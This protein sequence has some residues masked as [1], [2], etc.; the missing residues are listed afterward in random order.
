M[1]K[2][3]GSALGHKPVLPLGCSSLIHP[4]NTYSSSW[5]HLSR[6]GLIDTLIRVEFVEHKIVTLATL[7]P[8]L[9]VDT[10]ERFSLGTHISL[11]LFLLWW[12]GAHRGGGRAKK[13]GGGRDQEGKGFVFSSPAVTSRSNSKLGNGKFQQGRNNNP[14]KTVPR[15]FLLHW[16]FYTSLL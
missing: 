7:D 10:L 3:P 12:G 8:S 11:G 4:S 14:I 16:V 6:P 2:S 13:R 5:I 1:G 15:L 9:F